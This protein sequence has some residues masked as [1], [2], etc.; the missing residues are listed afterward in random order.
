MSENIKDFLALNRFIFIVCYLVCAI[1]NTAEWEFNLLISGIIKLS[2]DL[3]LLIESIGVL[4]SF[5]NILKR[6][7]YKI[8]FLV[9][10]TFMF[11]PIEIPDY[12]GIPIVL[13]IFFYIYDAI[14]NR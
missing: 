6:I 11:T 5:L 14:F 12:F 8:A 2:V 10:I 1:I 4:K 9:F 7:C 3:C 13:S